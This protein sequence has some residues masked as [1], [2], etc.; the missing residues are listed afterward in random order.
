MNKEPLINR[1]KEAYDASL[2]SD[3]EVLDLIYTRVDKI[4][5]EVDKY[6]TD[7]NTLF[8]TAEY[9]FE[10]GRL[11][12]CNEVMRVLENNEEYDYVEENPIE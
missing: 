12:A 5:K 3:G 11:E 2:I 9:N 8:S 4:L 1:L 10:H 7:P 6:M